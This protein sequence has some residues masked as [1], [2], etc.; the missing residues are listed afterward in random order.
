MDTK[1][2]KIK[3]YIVK[4]LLPLIVFGVIVWYGTIFFIGFTTVHG[5]SME[6]TLH[7]Q[8]QY[9]IQKQA[10]LWGKP[11]YKDIVIIEVSELEERY[12]IKRVIGKEG[13][14]IEI[15]ENELYRNGEKIQE[16]Y[17]LEKMDTEDFIVKVP[18]HS[19]FVMGDNR[20]N[21]MDGRELGCLPCEDIYGKVTHQ[22]DSIFRMKKIK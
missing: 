5:E 10:Y 4:E 20:N 11:Q 12:L 15:K 9:F 19:V 3:Q 18:K 8:S 16:P 21:S 1:E 14:L 6:P 17:I 2:N 13:D 22:V 7:G